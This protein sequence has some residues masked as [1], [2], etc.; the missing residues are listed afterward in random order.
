MAIVCDGVY[1]SSEEACGTVQLDCLLQHLVHWLAHAALDAGFGQVQRHGGCGCTG[2]TE[3]PQHEVLPCTQL[4]LASPLLNSSAQ[5][6]GQIAWDMA[7]ASQVEVLPC[8]QLVPAP[9]L[10]DSSL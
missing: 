6:A 2:P 1:H 9:P 8:A 10:L 4:A 7:E 3:A 5:P